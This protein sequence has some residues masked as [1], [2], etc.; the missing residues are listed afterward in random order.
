MPAI[1]TGGATVQG[2]SVGSGGNAGGV[3]GS[4][5]AAPT[6]GSGREVYPP[7]FTTVKAILASNEGMCS[8]APCHPSSAR[9]SLVDNAGLLMRMTS[10]RSEACGM[11]FVTPGN[12]E[13]S[14]FV[15]ILK[16]PCGETPQMPYDCI[17]GMFGTCLPDDYVAVIEKW[18][19]NGAKDD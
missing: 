15:N 9:L 18:I 14:A 11:P 13:M 12:P 7:T 19:E 1:P 3:T 17:P 4:S 6:R 8:A 16:G 5:G 2:G 10:F